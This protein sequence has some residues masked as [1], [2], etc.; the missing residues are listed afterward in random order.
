MGVQIIHNQLDALG[1]WIVNIFKTAYQYSPI[2][3]RSP[4]CHR[5]NTPTRQRFINHEDICGSL[6]LVLIV[7]AHWHSRFGWNFFACLSDQLD[8]YLIHTYHRFI[9]TEGLL[10]D[11]QD[12]L[13]GT[14]KFGV[15][16]WRNAPHFFSH[17]LSSFFLNICEPSHEKRS[18]QFSV[19]P[20][21]LPIGAGSKSQNPPDVRRSK[22]PPSGL[23]FR[24]PALP[25]EPDALI[26]RV[27]ICGSPGRVTALGHPASPSGAGSNTQ[28]LAY[29]RSQ[30]VD[31]M[32]PNSQ[33]LANL[34]LRNRFDG[35]KSESTFRF[36]H[37]NDD[38]TEPKGKALS[39][40]RIQIG[41]SQIR[42]CLRICP[43]EVALDAKITQIATL[44]IELH[45]WMANAAGKMLI[46][47]VQNCTKRKRE[48]PI[49]FHSW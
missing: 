14:N 25:E 40:L 2:N 16:F 19:P 11:F 26:V 36:G 41:R 42:K 7:N 4:F 15:I 21:G 45:A 23:P 29:L 27:R 10:I 18:Q 22:S 20:T 32:D 9:G 3:S 47:L 30:A 38:P 35:F 5:Y 13:H 12:I 37:A 39:L 43:A 24:R 34:P 17:G 44:N 6:L 49:D 48:S 31:P 8:A 1:L 46:C 33:V 28:A